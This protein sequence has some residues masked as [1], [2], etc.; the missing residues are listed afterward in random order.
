MGLVYKNKEYYVFNKLPNGWSIVKGA[1]TA[2]VGYRWIHNGK[3]RF[4]KERKL[5]FLKEKGD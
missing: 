3:S 2:P 5:A 4:S 1:T